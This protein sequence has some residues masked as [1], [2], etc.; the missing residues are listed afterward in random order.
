MMVM[1]FVMEETVGKISQVNEKTKE[2]WG[3]EDEKKF[4]G[5]TKLDFRV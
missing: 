4:G 1:L 3:N 2:V 5:S